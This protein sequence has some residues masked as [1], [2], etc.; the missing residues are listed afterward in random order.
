MTDEEVRW[1]VKWNEEQAEEAWSRVERN[2]RKREVLLT[3]IALD[4]V[5]RFQA[6]ASQLSALLGWSE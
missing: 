5:I 2:V 4:D 6:T 3:K 1:A